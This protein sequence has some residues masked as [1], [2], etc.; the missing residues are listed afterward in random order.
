MTVR[1]IFSVLLILCMLLSLVPAGLAEEV[2]EEVQVSGEEITT[3]D[4]PAPEASSEDQNEADPESVVEEAAEII[5]EQVPETVETTEETEETETTE[6]PATAEN[7][8]VTAEPS[9]TVPEEED[10]RLKC[11]SVNGTSYALLQD[12]INAAGNEGT[13][14]TVDWPVGYDQKVVIGKDQKITLDLGSYCLACERVENF[15]EL[16]ITG[17]TEAYFSGTILT[18][19]YQQRDEA[20]NTVD[21]ASGRT[22]ILGGQYDAVFAV[23]QDG[24]Q[25]LDGNI[26]KPSVVFDG[27]AYVSWTANQTFVYG[28]YNGDEIYSSADPASIGSIQICS[29]TFYNNGELEPYIAPGCDANVNY[30]RKQENAGSSEPVIEAAAEPAQPEETVT[31]I[32]EEPAVKSPSKVALVFNE[33]GTVTTAEGEP[34][35]SGTILTIPEGGSIL[36]YI[37]PLSN[38]EISVMTLSLDGVL[39]SEDIAMA[40]NLVDTGA[41]YALSVTF[42]STLCEVNYAET[43]L[44]SETVERNTLL[45]LPAPEQTGYRFTGWTCSKDGAAYAAGDEYTVT[46]SVT[47][48]A[49]WE[50]LVMEDVTFNVLQGEGQIEFNGELF[51]DG[52]KT[53]IA[54]YEEPEILLVADDGYEADKLTTITSKGSETYDENLEEAVEIGQ[55][56][57]PLTVNAYFSEAPEEETEETSVQAMTQSS[58]A[59]L[60]DDTATTYTITVK[61]NIADRGDLFCNGENLTDGTGSGSV[62]VLEGESVTITAEP[63]TGYYVEDAMLYYGGTVHEH[64][65]IEPSLQFTINAPE[66]QYDTY[67]FYVNFDDVES[68]EVR[69][70]NNYD[71]A[72]EPAL[73]ESYDTGKIKLAGADVVS[74]EGYTF[75][76]WNTDDDG[77]GTSYDAGEEIYLTKDLRLYAQWEAAEYTLTYNT[78]VTAEIPSRTFKV[79][80]SEKIVLTIPTETDSGTFLGWYSDRALTTPITEINPSATPYN[81]TVYGKWQYELKIEYDSTKGSVQ[82]DGTEVSSPIAMTTGESVVLTATPTSKYYLESASLTKTA[83]G[84]TQTIATGSPY[85]LSPGENSV[86]NVNFAYRTTVDVIYDYN[87]GTGRTVTITG[88]RGDKT[89]LSAAPVRSGY[90]FT[91]W[92]CNLDG[93]FY[94]ELCDY[95]LSEDVTFT[96]QWKK[97]CTVRVYYN[98]Y[99][100]VTYNGATVPSGSTITLSEGDSAT[101]NFASLTSG[102]GVYN[103]T[104]NGARQGSISAYTVSNISGE[105]TIVVTFARNTLSPITGDSSNIFLWLGL[106]A[107]SAVLAAGVLIVL[108]KRKK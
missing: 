59:S 52:D 78:N 16:T 10:T 3:L 97:I 86:F 1:K 94:P 71:G 75:T 7:I 12:A 73:K 89:V 23:L 81:V 39:M 46:E 32:A 5:E 87:N 92:L 9:E 80:D 69:Y 45:T 64:Y 33:G 101:F 76:N 2:T 40:L 93:Y 48:T 19:A 29:G 58:E 30:T 77:E 34:L 41:D 50:K 107:G 25:S 95:V 15:G 37:L 72:T 28:T 70:Y 13:I 42:E 14:V 74:R 38:Y 43:A 35:S 27:N 65:T 18:K 47:F 31:E 98:S 103:C 79:T 54:A 66:E 4:E 84:T 17:S 8:T 36:L 85:I 53:V 24:S 106:L 57:R 62:N 21:S 26:E 83:P 67:E 6:T 91:G 96:A 104:V 105:T 22:R 102:Y 82:K 56:T 44:E 55:V 60:L 108:K 51:S 99:G 88:N 49:Q 100:T 61:V 20:G 68:A 63:K 90:E 11:F